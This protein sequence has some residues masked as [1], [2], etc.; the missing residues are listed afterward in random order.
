MFV[1]VGIIIQY[2]RRQRSFFLV[3]ASCRCRFL[4]DTDLKADLCR[5]NPTIHYD[6][7]FTTV[8]KH[9]K[10]IDKQLDDVDVDLTQRGQPQLRNDQYHIWGVSHDTD[11]R[12]C[13][14]QG[15]RVQFS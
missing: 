6:I 7:S 14:F 11:P 1:P 9:L 3:P 5:A 2:T 8:T 4:D 15:Q 13:D 12:V 10:D